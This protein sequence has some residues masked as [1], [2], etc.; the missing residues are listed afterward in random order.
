MSGGETTSQ[1]YALLLEVLLVCSVLSNRDCLSTLSCYS[2]VLG[3]L[4]GVLTSACSPADVS[5]FPLR[6]SPS[7]ES[8]LMLPFAYSLGLPLLAGGIPP[9]WSLV[10]G[11]IQRPGTS[12]AAG[13][14]YLGTRFADAPV[15]SA[16][17][18]VPPPWWMLCAWID[19]PR[20]PEPPIF[21]VCGDESRGRWQKLENS[22]SSGSDGYGYGYGYG[23]ARLVLSPSPHVARPRRSAKPRSNRRPQ[24]WRPEPKPNV[25]TAHTPN[26]FS[27]LYGADSICSSSALKT[28]SCTLRFTAFHFGD[29]R[30]SAAS[31]FRGT[32]LGSF[33]CPLSMLQPVLRQVRPSTTG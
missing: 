24:T 30:N 32:S 22:S 14:L 27:A 18:V 1:L 3:V 8:L 16:A 26:W 17:R 33:L 2:F 21:D 23:S 28:L 10:S 9:T 20:S 4:C 7:R 25:T 13:M 15:Q 12:E 29:F 19:A 6:C 11:T 5:L 31:E